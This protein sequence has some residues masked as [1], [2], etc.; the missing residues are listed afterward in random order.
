MLLLTSNGLSSKELLNCIKSNSNSCNS[1]VIITTAS[2]PFKINDKHIPKLSEE[3]NSIGFTVDFF[4]F[5]ENNPYEL[6]KYD[7]IEINGGNPFYLLNSIR[8]SGSEAI[9]KQIAKNKIL[10]GIS[11][12]A[13]VLQKNINLIAE[14][15]PEMNDKIRLNDL[16]GLGITN[17]EILPHYQR[18]IE[19]FEHFEER[20]KSY[21]TNNNCKVIRIDD[22]QGVLVFEDSF[23]II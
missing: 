5:D 20:A 23:K 11:A 13:V 22:G 6:L 21:E 7:L 8:K 10:V 19:R 15:S 9:I 4:D 16:T 17:I 1:A 18:F 12:G 2:V 3:L 14:H